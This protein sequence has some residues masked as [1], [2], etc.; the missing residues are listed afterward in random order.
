MKPRL[1]LVAVLLGFTCLA[2]M[3]A[4]E[5]KKLALSTDVNTA[6]IPMLKLEKDGYN[7]EKRHE[8]IMRLKTAIDPE[9]VLIGDSITHFWGGQPDGGRMG[10]RGKES[11]QN[12]FGARRVLN[13]GFGWDR[14]Q[15]V[16][17]R[18]ELGELDGLKP[19]AIVIH[20]GTN[21]TA[22]T[23]N[24]RSNT[25][26]EIVAGISAIVEQCQKRCPGAKIIL[27]AIFPRGKMPDHPKRAEL[28]R[29][30]TLLAAAQKDKPGVTWLDITNRWLQPDGTISTDIMP[31]SLHPSDKGY[32]IWAEA[33]RPLLP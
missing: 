28:A 4:E 16:L 33:L 32:G 23:E 13:L 11:W 1:I 17:K 12:L 22:Q 5:R 15:N 10:N 27:M 30:N 19:K 6:V 2:I 31:D 21:N 26:E 20:I 7:W 25:P 3:R 18:L 14:T 29:I 9:I 8:D 24:C